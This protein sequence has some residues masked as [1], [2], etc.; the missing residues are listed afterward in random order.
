MRVLL[1]LACAALV[2]GCSSGD[3]DDSSAANPA[4]NPTPP[5]PAPTQSA[6]GIWLGLPGTG[7]SATF[8]IA[9]TGELLAQVSALGATPPSPPSF[10]SGAVIVNN[11]NQVAGTYTLR[12]LPTGILI[13]GAAPPQQTCTLDGTVTERSLLQATTSCSDSAGN[14]TSRTFNMLYNPAYD[15]DSSLADIAGNYTVPFRPQTNTLNINGSGVVFGML[16]NGPTCTVN[17]QVQIIDA[18]FNLYRFEIQLSLCQGVI[19]QL[20]E[21]TTFRGF[22]ARNMPGLRPGAFIL[23]LNGTGTINAPFPFFSMLYE[24]V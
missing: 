22:A 4:T 1:S 21:G 5:A 18:R 9:E 16:D 10:G 23:L 14:T 19:G 6:G 2:A 20:Y 15:S 3:D 24:R 17:G 12:S 11:P 7:E 8:Y 13:P